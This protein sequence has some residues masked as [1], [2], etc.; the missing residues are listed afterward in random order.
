MAT[1]NIK[2]PSKLTKEQVLSASD[3]KL[4]KESEAQIKSNNALAK[5][6]GIKT[7]QD[8]AKES[9]KQVKKLSKTFGEKFKDEAKLVGL[10][11]ADNL[12]NLSSMIG[13][14]VTSGVDDF[15]DKY[16]SYYSNINTRLLG[17]TKTYN[18]I[19]GTVRD[20]VTGSRATSVL[21]VLDKLNNL[22]NQGI[23]YN[24][25]QRAFLEDLSGKIAT[26]FNATNTTLLQLVRLNRADST[27]AYLG[28]ESALTEFLNANFSD[29]NYLTTN[30]NESVSSAI[31][32]ATS[33]LGQYA[34]AEFEYVVQKWLGSFYESGVSQNT[35]QTIAQGLGYLG[36]GNV[37]ALTSNSQLSNLFIS[38]A[39]NAG[40][41]YSNLL[42]GGLNATDANKLL[43][44]IYNQSVTMA[45]SGDAVARSQFAS[46]F[47]MNVSDL[48]AMMKITS[49]DLVSIASNMYSYSD[50]ISKTE[51]ELKKVAART[52]V[53]EA[54]NNTLD[55]VMANIAEGIATNT[56]TYLTY[57]L[58]SMIKGQINIPI[59]FTSGI[60]LGT[61]MQAAIL[62]YN[63]LSKGAEVLTA[64]SGNKVLSLSSF[65]GLDNYGGGFVSS[66]G[67]GIMSRSTGQAT[68]Y[69]TSDSVA[70]ASGS[71]SE[72]KTKGA[73]VISDSDTSND[74][75]QE[76]MEYIKKTY[77]ILNDVAIGVSS[78]L[79]RKNEAGEP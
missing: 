17:T 20:S 48:T 23:A 58:A 63:V 1:G 49:N 29:T 11:M 31:Y 62:G 36:S 65:N 26:T 27:A 61:T 51:A 34:G 7:V 75:S 71:V 19:L 60:D 70:M 4:Q 68:Y 64:L 25:E 15:I 33:Q 43:Q 74:S 72:M 37:S 66:N 56:G 50:M 32:E 46:M 52:S 30:L 44:G 57:K 67:S 55:N 38:A 8:I 18:Q 54:I 41:N 13:S 24:I 14:K 22:L 78:F 16:S 3:K 42:T 77:N 21:S 59:P 5:Q 9:D 40:L 35:I 6:L 76:M 39:N 53:S 10:T 73:E 28:M 45:R 79:V 69:G 2:K 12:M 47:G